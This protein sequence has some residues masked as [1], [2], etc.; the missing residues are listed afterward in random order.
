MVIM[1]LLLNNLMDTANFSVT[2]GSAM[3][4]TLP[5]ENL[6]EASR[7]LVARSVNS[8]NT[9]TITGSLVSTEGV[10]CFVIGN[11]NFNVG[12]S[13]RVKLYTDSA[14]TTKLYDSDIITLTADN[15]ATDTTGGIQYNLPLWFDTVFGV[16]TFVLDITNSSSNPMPYF[17]YNRL[18]IGKAIIMNIGASLGHNLYWKENTLQ[19]RTEAGTLRSDSITASKIIEFSLNTVAESERSILQRALSVVGKRKDFFIS[20]FPDACEVATQL[21]YSGIVK[22]TKVPR[23]AEFAPSFY[24]SKYTVEEI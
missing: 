5:E 12:T 13:Y 8:P 4:P 10:N 11:H 9:Q 7:S 21:D 14:L 18:F 1:N 17:Q 2:A 3:H 6:K 24:S 22:M 19:Y 20:L 15:A 23:F 16:S